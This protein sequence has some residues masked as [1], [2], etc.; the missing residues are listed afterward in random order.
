MT[1]LASG[2]RDREALDPQLEEKHKVN[3]K[4]DFVEWM[5]CNQ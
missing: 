5:V 1:L 3:V 4:P 2:Y